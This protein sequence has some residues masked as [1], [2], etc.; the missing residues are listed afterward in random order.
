MLQST[1]SKDATT[2]ISLIHSMMFSMQTLRFL[3]RINCFCN[4][5]DFL[6][7]VSI[8]LRRLRSK[9]FIL[10]LLF[11]CV[12]VIVVVLALFSLCGGPFG[13]ILHAPSVSVYQSVDHGR[14]AP[15]HT[16]V[17]IKESTSVVGLDGIVAV[18]LC[19]H[20]TALVL[21]WFACIT[22]IEFIEITLCPVNGEKI[23]ALL[24]LFASGGVL[25]LG[26]CQLMERGH[27]HIV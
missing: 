22:I 8:L 26:T 7:S 9:R 6:V 12:L 17:G 4:R 13:L 15:I 16:H 18:V 5:M 1:N 27:C 14:L 3:L 10:Y 23:L 24:F 21:I 25:D 11:F 20:V 2:V 19:N